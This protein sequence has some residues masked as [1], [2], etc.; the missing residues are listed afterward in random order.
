MLI[1]LAGGM[2]SN[3]REYVKRNAPRHDYL[4]PS[5]HGL[6]HENQYTLW[7]LLA[8]EAA[9]LIFAY[10]ERDNPGGQ[11]LCIEIG[12]AKKSGKPVIF[13]EENAHRYMGMARACADVV[14]DSLE[15]GV[16]VLVALDSF[17]G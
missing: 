9:H 7:D 6:D 14:V 17:G 5:F 16:K 12:Y 4:D 3:W 15:E 1:Y 13:V 8:I 10:M 11:G 2:R